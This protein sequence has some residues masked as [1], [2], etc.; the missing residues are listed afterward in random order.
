MIKMSLRC[1]FIVFLSCIGSYLNAQDYIASTNGEIIRGQL[2]EVTRKYC[3]IELPGGE[4]KK[5]R[6]TNIR[7][8]EDIVPLAE[9]TDGK[10]KYSK[11][12]KVTVVKG[13]STIK[14]KFHHATDSTLV[15][16]GRGGILHTVDI[17]EIDEVHWR[18]NTVRTGFYVG[19]ITGLI[20][21]ALLGAVSST[22]ATG[23][24]EGEVIL[25][26]ALI[27][28][29]AGAAIGLGIDALSADKISIVHNGDLALWK[30]ERTKL[31]E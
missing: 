2:V 1:L 25:V 11:K 24:A 22:V 27:L 20:G 12:G 19:A 5:L 18:S 15:Y 23:S 8:Y 26:G 28:G 10:S 30:I 4:L 29:G 31:P 16:I 17:T 6:H 14:G 13:A 7:H 21:G 9:Y 3:I